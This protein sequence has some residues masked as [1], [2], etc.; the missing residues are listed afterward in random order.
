MYGY[1]KEEVRCYNIMI[2]SKYELLSSS[3]GRVRY[4]VW[5]GEYELLSSTVSYN[6][7]CDTSRV[8]L[9]SQYDIL[10]LSLQYQSCTTPVLQFSCSC[11]PTPVRQF[12][13]SLFCCSLFSYVQPDQYVTLLACIVTSVLVH[14]LIILS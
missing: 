13:C 6:C 1:C 5:V 8:P 9:L 4:Q 7:L 3:G 10:Q 12:S 14:N 11:S 2:L